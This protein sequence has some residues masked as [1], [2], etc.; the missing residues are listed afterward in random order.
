MISHTLRLKESR[1]ICAMSLRVQLHHFI[2]IRLNQ[3]KNPSTAFKID[4]HLLLFYDKDTNSQK[5]QTLILWLPEEHR[6][7]LDSVI[8]SSAISLQ[9]TLALWGCAE[10]VSLLHWA[11]LDRPLFPLF[12]PTSCASCSQQVKVSHCQDKDVLRKLLSLHI[13]TNF[14]H[15]V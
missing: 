14:S 7:T 9:Q 6:Q 8:E 13:K 11:A 3:I 2:Q 10:F 1:S 5:T 4:A 15:P 12:C